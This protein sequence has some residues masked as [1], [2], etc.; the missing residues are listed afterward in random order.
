MNVD[1]CITW[2]THVKIGKEKVLT[3]KCV[4]KVITFVQNIWC[5]SKYIDKTK[6][7]KKKINS[8]NKEIKSRIHEALILSLHL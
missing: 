3:I 5:D 1:W 7:K 6:K 8:G 4:E 2:S